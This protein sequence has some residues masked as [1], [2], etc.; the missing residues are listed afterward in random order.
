MKAISQNIAKSLK[1]SNLS[2]KKSYGHYTNLCIKYNY[3]RINMFN[4]EPCMIMEVEE[5]YKNSVIDHRMARYK[6]LIN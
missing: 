6:D 4:Y 2:K 5:K 1:M 3:P